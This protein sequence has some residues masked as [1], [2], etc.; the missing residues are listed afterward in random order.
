MS[1]D[2]CIGVNVNDVGMHT[3][4][5]VSDMQHGMT[6]S[7]AECADVLGG[8]EAHTNTPTM[9]TQPPLCRHHVLSLADATD[10][11]LNHAKLNSVEGD[12]TMAHV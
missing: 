4:L 1:V 11:L 8:R 3:S 12:C 6:G 5:G 10:D 2:A 7:D 9:R